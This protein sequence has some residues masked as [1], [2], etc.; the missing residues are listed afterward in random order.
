MRQSDLPA[1]QYHIIPCLYRAGLGYAISLALAQKYPGSHFARTRREAPLLLLCTARDE[2]RGQQAVKDLREAFASASSTSSSKSDI[3]FQY[4]QLDVTSASSRSAFLERLRAAEHAS[5]GRVHLLVNNAGIMPGGALSAS[6][7]RDVVRTNYESVRDF[8]REALPLLRSGAAEVEGEGE[9]RVVNMS[10]SLG[11]LSGNSY[12]DAIKRQ[13]VQASSESTGDQD[14]ERGAGRISRLMQSFVDAAAQGT[15]K[16]E[17]WSDSGDAPAQNRASLA[18]SVSK[19]GLSALTAA[20]QAEEDALADAHA[21]GSKGKG[22]GKVLFT[23]CCPGYVNTDM[24][25][26]RGSLTPEQGSRMPVT[27]ALEDL[28]AK[29]GSS[30]EKVGGSFWRLGKTSDWR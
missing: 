30:G 24:T 9:A 23:S 2:G 12:S 5:G 11:M 20:L 17:G 16:R 22:K 7:A 26:G 21:A 29:K 15:L 4:E 25:S 8:T 1:D 14:E 13:L 19:S 10:S 18:Y 6:I 27:L 3:S 28:E